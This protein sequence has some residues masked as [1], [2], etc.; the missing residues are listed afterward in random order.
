VS[1]TRPD[2]ADPGARDRQPDRVGLRTVARGFRGVAV[3]PIRLALSQ[4]VRE[5]HVPALDMRAID[6]EV[7]LDTV[8]GAAEPERLVGGGVVARQMHRARRQREGVVMP[9]EDGKIVGRDRE[10]RVGR[11]V[12]G[13]RHGLPAE[14]ACPVEQIVAAI[15]AGEQLAAK[16]DAEHRT[17][18]VAE[19]AHQGDEFREIGTAR[20]VQSVLPAAQHD[21]GVV[22]RGIRRQRVAQVG[23]TKIDH[24]IRL[25]ERPGE[26]PKPLFGK[27]L[28]HENPHESTPHDYFARTDIMARRDHEG[29]SIMPL[30]NRVDPFGEIHAVAARGIFTGNRGVI[31][32]P[33]T[34]TLLK[35]RWTTRAWIICTCEYKGWRREPMGR[36]AR[37]G[38]TGWTEL[39]FLDEVTALAAG[40]R[41]CFL[42]RREKAKEYA[43]AFGEAFGVAKPTVQVMDERLHRERMASA[44]GHG[45]GSSSSGLS[46]GSATGGGKVVARETRRR[47]QILGTSPRMTERLV[48][49]K[50]W[51]VLPDGTM[52]HDGKTAYALRGGRALRWSFEGYGEPV[53]LS[54]LDHETLRVLTPET[55]VA[56]LAGGFVPVWH[57]SADRAI[58]AAPSTGFAGPPPP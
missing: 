10:H 12:G 41:P 54:L 44:G 37:S 1:P 21:D 7:E 50:E 18:A 43:A 53:A 25:G 52:I 13:A 49:M 29:L 8:S 42:C 34:K 40:H 23:A 20:V 27:I 32:D 46:R 51:S 9:L 56:V 31:H 16:A 38:G 39:F 47:Q 24:G 2:G 57:S 28:H 36:N 4:D 45:A 17:V 15:G 55:T 5:N 58:A 19:V 35:R 22:A 33:M 14:F 3:L 6:L 48:G 26:L 30:Q 11:A